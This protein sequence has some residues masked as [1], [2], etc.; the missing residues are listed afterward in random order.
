[1][2]DSSLNTQQSSK[3]VRVVQ[4]TDPHLH[5]DPDKGLYGINSLDSFRAVYQSVDHEACDLMLLTGD[6][7]HDE[8]EYGYLRLA[9]DLQDAPYPVHCLPGNHDDMALMASVLNGGRVSCGKQIILGEWQVLL[10]NSA[11]AG[12]VHGLL[13]DNELL[14]LDSMLKAHPQ[15]HTLIALHHHPFSLG[16][17]WLEPL[18]LKNAD[19]LFELIAAH[20][21]VK[22]VL[23]GHVHQ[24][25][26]ED[27]AGVRFL[28]SPSTCI[29]FKP[30]TE[31]FVLDDVTPGYR[32]LE[33]YEDGRVETGVERIAKTCGV[34]DQSAR[35]Y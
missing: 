21:Q 8:T 27:R 33:L 20:P 34:L 32:W 28:A 11:V 23:W 10:L 1:M 9:R 17:K 24:E 35:G 3:P 25:Y 6:L 30:K 22:V 31:D 4:I 5:Q 2:T 15:H 16:C 14:W 29:Q 13:D 26:D 18:G 12:K 19:K 7:V